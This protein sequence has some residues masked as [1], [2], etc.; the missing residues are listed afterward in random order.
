[1]ANLLT[2][3]RIICGILL[4][5]FPAFSKQYYWFA[6]LGGFTDA[7]DGS[8]AR[9]VGKA[10][11][12]GAVYDTAADMVFTL[13]MM[14]KAVGTVVIPLWLAIWIVMIFIL[15]ALNAAAGFIKY[16]RFVSV[17]SLLNRLC[18]AAV[19][20]LLLLIGGECPKDA[21]T[22]LIAFGCLFASIAA[23]Q[24]LIFIQNGNRVE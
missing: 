5:C 13:A 22:L 12:F 15:K 8:V 24:E 11:R 10:T 2:T 3:A 9:R 17:H 4:L 18:G 21:K 7:I 16:R 23:V 6:V 19:F 20:V 1:M 14:I